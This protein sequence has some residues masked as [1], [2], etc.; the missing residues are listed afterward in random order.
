MVA[1]ATSEYN[2]YVVRAIS[3]Q[4][5]KVKAIIE[6]ELGREG[7]TKYVPEILIPL[8]KVYEVKNGQKKVREKNYFPGYI[9]INAQLTG[10]VL[11]LL[12]E[13]MEL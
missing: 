7:L 13:L 12:G 6:L 9:L 5:N 11:L 4:E 2:W 3:G 10:E 1:E 8:Q